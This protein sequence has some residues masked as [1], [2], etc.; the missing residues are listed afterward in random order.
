MSRRIRCLL[1]WRCDL[2]CTI[3]CLRLPF[4]FPLRFSSLIM[5]LVSVVLIILSL[6]HF[7]CV[8]PL[9]FVSCL[10]FFPSH[11]LCILVSPSVSVVLSSPSSLV[12][13]SASLS[14]CPPLCLRLRLSVCVSSSSSIVSHLSPIVSLRISQISTLC[15]RSPISTICHFALTRRYIIILN[16]FPLSIGSF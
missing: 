13:V 11:S 15:I 12:S 2:W 9:F 3:V 7:V 6:S 1:A 10:R 14:Q 16:L 8:C 4:W 5:F